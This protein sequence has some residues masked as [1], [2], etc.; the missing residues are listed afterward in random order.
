M[1]PQLEEGEFCPPDYPTV[2]CK[3]GPRV[4]W[5]GQRKSGFTGRC[6]VTM[7][8]NESALAAA[9]RK[10]NQLKDK[11]GSSDAAAAKKRTKQSTKRVLEGRKLRDQL[12]EIN[13]LRH[14]GKAREAGELASELEAAPAAAASKVDALS[15]QRVRELRDTAFSFGGLE[16]TR[17]IVRRFCDLPEVRPLLTAELLEQRR[18]A[19]DSETGRLRREACGGPAQQL[20]QQLSS[21]R[22]RSGSSKCL[23]SCSQ[24]CYL[25]LVSACGARRGCAVGPVF[26][27]VLLCVSFVCDRT[28]LRS[29]ARGVRDMRNILVYKTAP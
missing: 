2:I 11:A 29:A 4:V 27:S 6:S 8:A 20:T 5:V 22:P 1:Q 18:D 3:A 23:T 13:R 12:L 24:P 25:R 21:S 19:V 10:L 17:Q 14:V 7:R 16:L 9:T 15:R 28:V 26:H